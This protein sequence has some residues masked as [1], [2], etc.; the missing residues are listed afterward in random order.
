MV[1]KAYL[2]S[3]N[4]NVCPAFSKEENVAGDEREKPGSYGDVQGFVM[5]CLG[6]GGLHCKIGVIPGEDVAINLLHS[7]L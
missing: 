3:V 4:L 7:W 2:P 6:F 5:P 1:D